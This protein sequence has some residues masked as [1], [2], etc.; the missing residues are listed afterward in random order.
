MHLLAECCLFYLSASLVCSQ[1]WL[2]RAGGIL[3]GVGGD[4]KSRQWGDIQEA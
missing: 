3:A 2:V 4:R 1:E